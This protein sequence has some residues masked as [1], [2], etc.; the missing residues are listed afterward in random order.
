MA[1]KR[2]CVDLTPLSEETKQIALKELRETPENVAEA[3][4]ELKML[5]AADTTIYYR[6]DDDFLMIF[7][8][9]TKFYAK[10]AHALVSTNYYNF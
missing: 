3:L 1:A 10:S 7:L 6:T 2:F 5:L 8:R 9:P 4:K